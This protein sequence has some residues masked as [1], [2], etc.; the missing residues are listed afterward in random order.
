MAVYCWPC[1]VKANCFGRFFQTS[2]ETLAMVRGRLIAAYQVPV[3]FEEFL[4]SRYHI[5]NCSGNWSHHLIT[6]TVV[7]SHYPFSWLLSWAKWGCDK[8]HNLCLL[9]L[10][11]IA[12]AAAGVQHLLM[13]YYVGWKGKFQRLLLGPYY[14]NGPHSIGQRANV[15]SLLPSTSIPIICPYVIYGK[16]L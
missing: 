8:Y 12:A 15:E 6:F 9:L 16:Q 4:Q 7:H 2:L 1:Q 10:A 5:W 3:A 11:L 14:H 13:I